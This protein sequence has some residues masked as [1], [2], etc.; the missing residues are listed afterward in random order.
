MVERG[1]AYVGNVLEMSDVE[2][3]GMIAKV[4]GTEDYFTRVFLD[5]DG[6]LESECSCPVHRRCKHAVAT[7]LKCGQALESD[8]SLPACP[9]EGDFWKSAEDAIAAR[10]AVLDEWERCREERIKE[11]ERLQ[12]EAAEVTRRAQI[13][14]ERRY[15]EFLAKLAALSKNVLDVC[16]RKDRDAMF[17]AAEEF[18]EF[19]SPDIF[20]TVEDEY[21]KVDELVDSTM[22]AVVF[23]LLDSGLD[24]PALIF[25]A[26]S[27]C[28]PERFYAY[29]GKAIRDLTES[30]QGE[31]AL[32]EVWRETAVKIESFIEERYGRLDSN[33]T[34]ENTLRY[35]LDSIREAW[36]RAG[37]EKCAANVWMKYCADAGYWKET[38]D[39]LN[40]IGR[41]D[42]AILVA[43]DGVKAG[44]T[45][46]DW[47]NDYS[48]HMQEP[49][50]DAF[51]GKGDHL[52]AAA[53]LAEQFLSWMGCYEHHRSLKS[54][55]KLLDEAEKAGL[56]NE[57]RAALIQ[58]LKTGINPEPLH[59][60]KFK[61]PVQECDWKPVPKKVEY[62]APDA[63]PKTPTWPLPKANEGMLL[64]DFRWDTM[65]DWCQFDQ[66]FLLKLALEDGDRD[67]VALRFCNL[68]Q[69]PRSSD[70]CQRNVKPM[71]DA[72][73]SKMLGYR[74]DIVAV[75]DNP[76]WHWTTIKRR[77]HFLASKHCSS[78]DRKE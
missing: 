32:P 16:T 13:D 26:Y 22:A 50:A 17:A 70:F 71:I 73:R 7:I 10:R 54:F 20:L 35:W 19:A 15:G 75:I 51:V 36:R 53:I 76:R 58:A 49:L 78:C 44:A 18:L 3:V 6:N 61:P 14:E 62:A 63:L 25:W 8:D 2:G 41:Y 60:W 72:V 55:H 77:P 59:H 56:R 37:G 52:K 38:A 47:G 5:G 21:A 74:D 34:N 40:A 30:P 48:E 4:H 68:P 9:E 29:E 11:A 67:E 42:D 23:A 39:F 28:A 27:L 24:K 66:E 57:V 1:E 45:S 33:G 31:F 64:S 46:S 12:R 65:W 69:Y 43:R